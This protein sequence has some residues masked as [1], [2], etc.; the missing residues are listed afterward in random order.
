MF[1]R[2]AHAMFDRLCKLFKSGA[3][4]TFLL[5]FIGS[6]VSA[7]IAP[8]TDS[9]KAVLEQSTGEQRIDVLLSLSDQMRRTSIDSAVVYARR[10]LER[11]SN[12][13]NEILEAKTHR[14][15][16]SLLLSRGNYPDALEHLSTAKKMFEQMGDLS[17]EVLTLKNL[18]A[19]YKNQSD[20][21]KAL[22]YYFSALNLSEQLNEKQRLPDI[23]LSIGII[24]ERLD[25]PEKSIAY[26]KR[27]IAV[28][29]ELNDASETAIISMSL[30]DL[31]A[32]MGQTEEALE[33]MHQALEASEALPGAHAQA[34]ILMSISS[35]YQEGKSYEKALEANNRALTLARD[36]SDNMLQSLALQNIAMVYR[37]QQNFTQA[38]EYLL[39]TRPILEE[40]GSQQL[41]IEN[42]NQIARNYFDLGEFYQSITHS[43]QAYDRAYKAGNFELAQQSLQL[44]S[45]GYEQVGDYEKAFTIQQ[46]LA[47]VKDSLFS[48]ERSRQIAEMQTRYET[49]EKEQE[50]ALLQQEQEKAKL[51]R[52]AFAAGLILI[53]IIGFLVYNRQ[54]LKIKKNRTELEN[55]RLKEQQ[56]RQDLEFKNKQL[57]THSLNLVQKNEVM[58]EL[59]QNIQEIKQEPNGNIPKKL[60]NIEHLINYS[61]NLDEDWEEFKLYFEEIHTGFFEM[62]KNRYPDLTPNELRLSALVKLNLTIKEIATIMGISPDSVKTARYRLRKKLGMETEENLT[63][64]MMDI[65][66]ES[67]A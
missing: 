59:K 47:A 12:F 42:E 62:L 50:I 16:G 34:T 60:N 2:R 13:G 54:R 3:G 46:A 58:K 20:H 52:N 38:I 9:L 36:M 65:E 37:E 23:L 8:Q 29:R 43:R 40:I 22:E 55:N 30:G 7:Q 66:K 67:S 14:M 26:Y 21:N 44:L 39:Q 33:A 45:S 32:S 18:G 61:F 64:F 10:A 57:T 48:R 6:P 56:L 25:Q 49:K 51:G 5:F 63:A 17:N 1:Y 31:Y 53:A 4:I 19:L 28:S 15:L 24:N 27:A 35:V 11:S 41:I